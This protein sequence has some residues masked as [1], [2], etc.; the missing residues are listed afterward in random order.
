MLNTRGITLRELMELSVL[1]KAK[2]I[3]GQQGAGPGGP[4]RR[5]YGGSGSEG[6]DQ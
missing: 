6:L 3:S 5:Y 2:V 4:V 1:G